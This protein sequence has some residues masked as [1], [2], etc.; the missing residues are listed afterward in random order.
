MAAMGKNDNYEDYADGERKAGNATL[1]TF[2][3]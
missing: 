3:K 1:M 2:V